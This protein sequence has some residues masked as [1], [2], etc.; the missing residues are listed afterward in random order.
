MVKTAGVETS[1]QDYLG[2]IEVKNNRLEAI[3]NEEGRAYN[4]SN[5][6][7]VYPYTWRYEYNLK[8]H[9]G[10]TRVV[11]CDKNNN[12][13]IEDQT[14]ILQETHYYPFG[15]AFNGSWYADNTASKYKYLYNGKELNEDFGLN[16][17]DYGARWY[18]ASIGRWWNVDPLAI[19]YHNY[20]P[21]N[22]VMNNPISLIDPDGMSASDKE[23]VGADGLTNS[24]WINASRP[25]ADKNLTKEYQ[26][27]NR[28]DENATKRASQNEDSLDKETPQHSATGLDW[29]GGDCNCDCPGK[30]PCSVYNNIPELHYWTKPI[31]EFN[32]SLTYG[33]SMFSTH[34]G[35]PLGTLELH[36]QWELAKLNR[37]KGYDFMKFAYER[38]VLTSSL[39]SSLSNQAVW[40]SRLN[41]TAKHAGR[42]FAV[43]GAVAAVS[44]YAS[45]YKSGYRL[46]ADL[47]MTYIGVVGGPW[48]LAASG[49]YF[50]GTT[51]YDYYNPPPPK[52]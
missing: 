51:A 28:A 22:Y 10:N 48:G 17:S 9:L 35:L 29:G 49:I 44:D 40:A 30:P 39:T 3:Y 18:D 33:Q 41:F 25:G 21:Y 37:L 5:A 24:Q 19:L 8:D 12:G 20:T 31:S 26:S 43:Y 15:M 1:R 46:T 11:F 2:G 7:Q 14:E 16:L 47:T 34:I 42:L 27:N 38:P 36:K 23:S 13:K 45:G 6:A 32:Q 52:P 50:I 4:T